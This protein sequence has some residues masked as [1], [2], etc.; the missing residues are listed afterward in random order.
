MIGQNN[1]PGVSLSYAQ[2]REDII[3]NAFFDNAEDGF[4]VDIGANHPVFDSVTKLFY[5]KGWT[6]VDIE[7]NVKLASMI[8]TDRPLDTVLQVGV[9]DHVGEETLRIYNNTGLSTFSKKIMSES[10]EAYNAHKQKYIDVRVRVD[11]LA[12]ILGGIKDL[13]SIDFM[14][15][16]VEGLEYEVLKGNDWDKFRPELICVEANHS[17]KNWRKILISNGYVKFFEDGLNEYYAPKESEKAQAFAFPESVLMKYPKILPFIPHSDSSIVTEDTFLY[18][19]SA[20]KEEP[21]KK[22]LSGAFN[23]F[24]HLLS[25]FLIRNIILEKRTR[26]DASIRKSIE[27]GRGGKVNKVGYFTPKILGLRVVFYIHTIGYKVIRK[28]A[29]RGLVK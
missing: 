2:N 13:K 23:V 20:E 10:S 25:T 16:D 9:S 15:V 24:N 5:L 8:R 26:L 1:I 18:K 12:N 11:T 4:Y 14:K 7:P 27:V 17:D 3:I 28:I 21:L 6:G 19:K 29:S 22:R